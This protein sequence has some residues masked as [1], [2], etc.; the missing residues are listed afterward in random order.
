MKQLKKGSKK[1]KKSSDDEGTDGES[2]RT[3]AK[4][5]EKITSPKFPLS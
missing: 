5:A 4:E 2:Q 1:D 3:K